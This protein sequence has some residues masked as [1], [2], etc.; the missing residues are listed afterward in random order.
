MCFLLAID[1]RLAN[2]EP[3]KTRVGFWAAL[4]ARP[5]RKHRLT[6]G[7]MCLRSC[8]DGPHFYENAG[9]KLLTLILS[10]TLDELNKSGHHVPGGLGTR[11]ASTAIKCK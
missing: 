3:S 7:S 6:L 10:R 5:F 2:A 9:V 4:L 8:I 11:K 1:Y